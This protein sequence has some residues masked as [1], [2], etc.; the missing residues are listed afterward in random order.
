VSGWACSDRVSDERKVERY[1]RFYMDV[2]RRAAELS[3]A[4]RRKVGAVAVADGNIMAFGFNG[5]PAGHP[6]VCEDA[7]GVTLPTVIH[8]E[9]NLIRKLRDSPE[10]LHRRCTVYVTK[11]PC[12]N[13]ASL[14]ASGMP[15]LRTLVYAD[16]SESNHGVG[17]AALIKEGVHVIRL[18]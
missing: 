18:T 14:L 10:L 11:E 4:K 3:F 15:G 13:C 8:A 6:N 16:C 2:A 12:L 5:T 9:D 1:N 7:D 17:L